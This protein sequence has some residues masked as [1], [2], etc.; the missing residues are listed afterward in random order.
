MIKVFNK[1]RIS[2]KNWQKKKVFSLPRNIYFFTYRY[3][4]IKVLYSFVQICVPSLLL[5]CC[6]TKYHLRIDCQKEVNKNN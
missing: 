2:L 1:I 5:L 3:L 4:D 6:Q